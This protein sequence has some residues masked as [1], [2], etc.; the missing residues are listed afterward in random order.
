MPFSAKTLFFPTAPWVSYCK[1]LWYDLIFL[2]CFFN[3]KR[4]HKK[5]TIEILSGGRLDNFYIII[6]YVLFEDE[7]GPGEYSDTGLSPCLPCAKSTYQNNSMSTSC[8]QCPTG[9]TTAFQGS[10]DVQNCT[11][12]YLYNKWLCNVWNPL[13]NSQLATKIFKK[14][15]IWFLSEFDLMFKHVGNKIEIS[16]PSGGIHIKGVTVM[17]W[18]RPAQDTFDMTVLQSK[19]LTIRLKEKLLIGKSPVV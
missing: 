4:I 15:L 1:I 8:I 3:I 5:Y 10:T 6:S 18:M 13:S 19:G 12:M 7:C 9:L 17:L 16:N 2:I 11:G 14:L